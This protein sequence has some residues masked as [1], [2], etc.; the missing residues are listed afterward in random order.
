MP[1]K[2]KK[3]NSIFP[4][5]LFKSDSIKRLV[6]SHNEEQAIRI[7]RLLLSAIPYGLTFAL[8]CLSYW[9]GHMERWVVVFCAIIAPISFC[10]FYIWIRSGLNLHMKDPSLT[11]IQMVVSTLVILTLMYN[12]N[13]I[14][15]QFLITYLIVFIFGIFKLDTRQFMTLTIFVLFTYGFVIF[16]LVQY[17]P[18][19]IDLHADVLQWIALS[20]LLPFFAYI[21]GYISSL[22]VKLRNRHSELKNAMEVIHDM[23]IRDEL[24]GLF[25]RRHLMNLLDIEK[26]RA[27]RSGFPFHLMILDIDHFKK[28]ND[29]LGHLAGDKVLRITARMVQ[30][31]LR[32]FDFCGRYGGEEFVLMV[33]QTA[34]IGA[35]AW[36]ERIRKKVESLRFTDLPPDFNVTISLGIAEYQ[37]GEELSDTIS[38]ADKALYRAKDAGRNRVEFA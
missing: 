33:G 24:T 37:V 32:L 25:N 8:V 15:G 11:M 17:H 2:G 38:R 21:G 27:D 14:R 26:A 35:R 10:V 1:G 20:A 23:A 34:S 3:M 22:R 12:A 9:L 6:L 5:V 13:H 36:A 30:N 18:D 28:V 29:S 16:M 19:K 31:E 4:G 7:S